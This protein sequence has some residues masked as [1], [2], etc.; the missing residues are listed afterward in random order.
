MN[1]ASKRGPDRVAMSSAFRGRQIG[2]ADV[3]D[4]ASHGYFVK[5]PFYFSE[6][7]PRSTGPLSIFYEKHLI[8]F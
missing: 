7:N 6:I 2:R 3:P 4:R 8:L 5:K 1:P